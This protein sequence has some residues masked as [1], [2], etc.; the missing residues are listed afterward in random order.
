MNDID[1]IMQERKATVRQLKN[2]PKKN[3]IRIPVITATLL[4]D[5]RMPRKLGVVISATYVRV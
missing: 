5:A 2:F 4:V 1:G 3:W